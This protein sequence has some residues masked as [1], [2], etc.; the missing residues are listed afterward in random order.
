MLLHTTSYLSIED[1]QNRLNVSTRTVYSE[2]KRMNNWLETRSILSATQVYLDFTIN[3]I[4][5]GRK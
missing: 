4:R 2:I 5:L 1:L 3:S